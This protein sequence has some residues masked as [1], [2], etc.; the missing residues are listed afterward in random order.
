ML[1]ELT[2]AFKKADGDSL[3]RV[4]VL[5][6]AGRGF[7]PGQDLASAVERGAGS[8]NFSYSEHL[9]AHYNPLILG[10]RGLSKPIIAA[11]NGVAACA[12]GKLALAGCYPN[13]A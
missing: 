11:I 3:V 5:T 12:R 8:G 6:G 1:D 9:R 2:D 10:L 4:V 7:C 13:T